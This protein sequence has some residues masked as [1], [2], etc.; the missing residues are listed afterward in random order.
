MLRLL[1]ALTLSIAAAQD[2]PGKVEPA[3]PTDLVVA[4]SQVGVTITTDDASIESRLRRVLSATGYFEHVEI[5]VKDGVV[6]LTGSVV[7]PSAKEW[8]GGL[9]AKTEGVV[10]VLNRRSPN[11][12]RPGEPSSASCRASPSLC[13]CSLA[14]GSRWA[15]PGVCCGSRWSA[16]SRASCCAP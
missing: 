3:P 10:A 6:I 11:C 12:G 16:G 5:R 8:V 9:V 4:E 1:A 15:S 7:D 14:W 2:P 13:W